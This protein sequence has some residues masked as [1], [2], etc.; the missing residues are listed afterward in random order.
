MPRVE[1]PTLDLL[2][3]GGK[4]PAIILTDGEVCTYAQL[5]ERVAHEVKRWRG[6]GLQ[7]GD[8]VIVVARHDLATIVDMLALLE[9]NALLVPV[10]PDLTAAERESLARET[11]ATWVVEGGATQRLALPACARTDGALLGL[12][13]SGSTGRPK[14]VLRSREQILAGMTIY[15]ES[16]ELAPS[17]R[18]LA[19]LPLEHSYGI[20]NVVLATLGSGVTLI[21]ARVPH[22]RLAMR[23]ILEHRVTLLPA[24]PVFFELMTKFA[25]A[26]PPQLPL[27][28]AI[29]VGTALARRIAV[30]FRAAFGVSLWQSYGTSESG[31]VALA[32]RGTPH[33]DFLALG[34]IC[35]NVRVRI[36]NDAGIELPPGEVGEMVIDSPAVALG[37]L[38][39]NDGASR[40]VGRSFFT[41]DLGFFRDGELFFAGRRKLLIAAAGHKVDP[42]EIENVLKEH[43]SIHD[44]AVLGIPDDHGIEQITAFI[45]AADGLTH[46]DVLEH[47]AQRLAPWKV[48]RVIHF[49]DSLPRNPMGKLLREKLV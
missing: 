38:G 2:A 29:S 43:P 24:A 19:L 37:Y 48:P 26:S 45:C 13:S 16:V 20:H 15:A 1:F 22:P 12:L 18:I 39:P 31:P 25:G 40:F 27:R 47:C 41:G 7:R 5:A 9:L 23:I 34:Q 46:Q 21:L 4:K 14:I 35:P 42:L 49:R 11:H 3:A 6:E 36:L 17:D 32:K 30:H 28:A 44:A 33:G 8:A 10:S